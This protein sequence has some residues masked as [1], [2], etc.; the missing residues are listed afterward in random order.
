MSSHHDQEENRWRGVEGPDEYDIELSENTDYELRPRRFGDSRAWKIVVG[1]VAVALLGS[2]ALNVVLP[3]L[4]SSTS[5]H[6][7]QIE[8]VEGTVKRVI[9]GRTIGVEIDGVEVTVRYIGVEIPQFGAPLYQIAT[10]ANR[11][12]VDGRSVLLEADRVDTDQ[13][14]R[15]LRYVWVDGAIV[16]FGLVAT[17][18]ASA[19]PPSE[20]D[21]F[22]SAFEELE[23]AARDRGLGIWSRSSAPGDGESA[24]VPDLRQDLLTP[25]LG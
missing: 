10:N 23:N 8:R 18:L 21:R 6:P 1:G 19:A 2:L 9:D 5:R 4:P 20:N 16:N 17:G 3:A 7:V 11:Q 12:W 25:V 24:Y 13:Q 14:G 15:L 22:Q